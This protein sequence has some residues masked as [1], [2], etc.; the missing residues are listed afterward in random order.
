MEIYCLFQIS[1]SQASKKRQ[2][3]SRIWYEH[4]PVPVA[5]ERRHTGRCGLAADRP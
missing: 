2:L 4:V 5:A 1:S 3:R